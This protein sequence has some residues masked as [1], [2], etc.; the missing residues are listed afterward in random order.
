MIFCSRLLPA[1]RGVL[2]SGL[3]CLENG[4][5]ARPALD[6]AAGRGDSCHCLAMA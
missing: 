5:A 2:A 1:Q 3:L 6:E 4:F